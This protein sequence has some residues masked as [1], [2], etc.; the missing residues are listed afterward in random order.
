MYVIQASPISKIFMPEWEQKCIEN[1]DL[2]FSAEPFEVRIPRSAGAIVLQHNVPVH[3]SKLL[4]QTTTRKIESDEARDLIPWLT[5]ED[6]ISNETNIYGVVAI[7]IDSDVS[8]T[9]SSMMS[10]PDLLSDDP[11]KLEKALEAQRTVQRRIVQRMK[12]RISAATEQANT[13]VKRTLKINHSFLI[14]QWEK[15]IAE[16][17]GK[18]PPS[19]T[20][21]MGAWIL[22]AEIRAANESRQKM[23]DNMTDLMQRTS[24][25]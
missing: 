11:E 13:R 22:A 17:K 5:G 8:N 4:P 3:F 19:M 23:V 25:G 16:G 18:Y 10:N 12:E 24:A 14:Q 21:A 9:I 6:N 7:D 20:E 1:P 15:N 2:I